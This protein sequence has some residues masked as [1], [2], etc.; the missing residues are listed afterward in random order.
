METIPGPNSL[1]KASTHFKELSTARAINSFSFSG[2]FLVSLRTFSIGR[3]A[4]A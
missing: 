3:I 2:F 4:I 1:V